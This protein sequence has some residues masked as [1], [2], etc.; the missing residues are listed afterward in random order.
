MVT[1]RQ[2]ARGMV[3]T[4]RAMDRAAKQAERQ[5]IARQT[6][7]HRQA[8]LDA[9]ARDAAEYEEIVEALTGAHRA[10]FSRRDW[11][12]TATVPL[13]TAAERR[14]DEERA[15]RAKLEA[16]E[17]GWLDRLLRRGE[18]LRETLSAGIELARSR[19]DASHARAIE[20]AQNR[21]KLIA[22]AQQVVARDP[23]AMVAALEEHSN[24]GALPF[25]VEG[26]DTVFLDDRV[27]AV[28][29]GLDMD[30]MPEESVSLLA[31]GKASVKTIPNGK[32][33]EMHRDAICS[34]AVRVAM[35]FLATLPLEQVE[36][37][38]LT[39][40]LDRG[41]GH[42]KGAPVLHVRISEQALRIV[43][44]GRTD[45]HALVERLGGHMTWNRKDGFR[46]INAAAFGIDLE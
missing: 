14:D 39:D 7:L 8:V 11:L 31:S 34:A 2:F 1:S 3:R 38:M 42:I 23:D 20:A 19:D 13:E 27:V 40:I 37:L 15:A 24:L 5:R 25:S 46:A 26:L 44:L 30:D 43:N 12:R 17:P 6:A 16:Y 9:S 29:D 22:T 35:E 45:A 33:M 41:T 21:N 10:N 28:V 4:M 32:R 18:R 36:V